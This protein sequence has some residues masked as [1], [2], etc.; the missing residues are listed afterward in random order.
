MYLHN[1]YTIIH[2]TQYQDI[3]FN[4]MVIPEFEQTPK[5]PNNKTE[6]ISAKAISCMQRAYL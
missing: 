3:I 6:Y 2:F 1:G 4:I 5:Y